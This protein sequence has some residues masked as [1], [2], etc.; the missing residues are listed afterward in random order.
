MCQVT[1]HMTT[2]AGPWGLHAPPQQRQ[3]GQTETAPVN[4]KNICKDG[5]KGGH[6]E[7]NFKLIWSTL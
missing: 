2:G 4:H 3:Q 5:K 6:Y 7:H 1:S